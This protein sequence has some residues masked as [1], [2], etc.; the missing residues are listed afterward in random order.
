LIQITKSQLE[1][2]LGN[3]YQQPYP[4]LQA[5][6]Q[7]HLQ[8]PDDIFGYNSE[9]PV[10]NMKVFFAKEVGVRDLLENIQAAK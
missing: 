7:Q 9:G 10:S 5:I 8:H 1:S 4:N 2:G 6:G 3:A